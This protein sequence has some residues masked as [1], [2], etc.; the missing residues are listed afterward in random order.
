MAVCALAFTIWNVLSVE[1]FFPESAVSF[2]LLSGLCWISGR[3]LADLFSNIF[4]E[5]PDFI[6]SFLLGFFFI[7]STVLLLQFLLPFGLVIDG[8]IATASLVICLA[9]KTAL[10]KG[11]KFQVV[12]QAPDVPTMATLCLILVASSIWARS[13]IRPIE[14]SGDF[15]IF[16]PWADSFYHAY[17]IGAFS[18]AHGIHSMQGI[19]YTGQPLSFYHFGTYMIPAGL[20]A[21][22]VTTPYQA[23]TSFL[24]P[25][26]LVLSGM[27]AYTFTKKFWGPWAGFGACVALL[28]IP[29]P[30]QMGGSNNWYSYHWLQQVTPGALYGVALMLIAWLA[31]IEACRSG[32]VALLALSYLLALVCINYKSH[33]FFANSFLLLLYPIFYF[34]QLSRIKR[35]LWLLGSLMISACGIYLS[36]KIVALPFISFDGSAYHSY[37]AFVKS[38]FENSAIKAF[39]SYSFSTGFT[40]L[41]RILSFLLNAIMI[42]LNTFGLVGFLYFLLLFLLRKTASPDLLFL[43]LL[44]I[45]S[46]MVM[47]FFLSYDTHGVGTPEELI[48]RPFVWAYYL[49]CLWV[50]GA[51]GFWLHLKQLKLKWFGLVLGSLVLMMLGVICFRISG[52]IQR[53]PR[54]GKQFA[55]IKV[56]NSLLACCDFIEANSRPDEIVQDS[57]FDYYGMITALSGRHDYVIK[58]ITQTKYNSEQMSRINIVEKLATYTTKA[59]VEGFFASRKITWYIRRPELTK[60]SWPKELQDNLVFSSNG[61][62]VYRF[63]KEP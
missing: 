47:S 29:D 18:K 51:V 14:I 12:F 43:P 38:M 26:G 6:A 1:A 40:H 34:G 44:V 54:W 59:E 17:M 32:R 39:F 41:N 62:H 13:S 7:N 45:A 42:F 58:Y 21:L 60:L 19:F 56:S 20:S 52:D 15:T 55:N 35:A 28:L 61:Y 22:T 46:Y 33:V 49:V 25:F 30:S 23:F 31:M 57:G 9:I 24:L 4:P 36:H 16:K 5:T 2:L 27:A 53:G 8:I 11:R 10:Q 63:L 3:I 37:I 48:H 50:G